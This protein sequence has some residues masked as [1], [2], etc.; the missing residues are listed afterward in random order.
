LEQ[1]GGQDSDQKP[2]TTETDLLRKIE[3]WFDEEFKPPCYMTELLLFERLD[4]D[5]DFP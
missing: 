5:L 1:A 4:R 2:V 3:R